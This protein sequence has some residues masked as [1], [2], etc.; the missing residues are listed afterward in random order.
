MKLNRRPVASLWIGTEIR[1]LEQ[2]CLKS[3]LR[4]GHPVTIY[5]TDDVRNLPEG[6]IA[7]PATDI[8]DISSERI[9]ETS[10]SFWSNVF[11]YKM[12]QKTG[13]IWIDCDAFCHRPFPDEWE[14]IFAG[15]GMRGALNCGVVGIPQIGELMDQLIDYYDNL[16]DYPPWWNQRQ[17]KKLDAMSPDIAQSTRIYKTERTAF[18]PQAFTHF[19]KITGHFEKA[20]RSEVLYPVPFQLNDVFYDPYGKVEGWFTENTT[21]VHL[22]TNGT[23]PWWQNNPPLPNSY[24]A[25]MCDTV[26]IDA[27]ASLKGEAFD[28]EPVKDAILY[29]AVTVK[30]AETLKPSGEAINNRIAELENTVKRKERRAKRENRVSWMD[31]F[32]NGVCGQLSKGDLAIDLGT[33]IGDISQKLLDTGADVIGFDP[34][35]L[36]ASKIKERFSS[37]PHYTF[38]QAAATVKDGHTALFRDDKFNKNSDVTPSKSSIIAGGKWMLNDASMEVTVQTVNFTQFLKTIIAERGRIAFLK[39]AIEGAEIEL[40]EEMDEEGLF[41]YIDCASIKTYER[42]FK[43]LRPRYKL[44]RDFFEEKYS[45][46]HVNFNWY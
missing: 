1:Y 29:E 17:R 3:H 15:H 41:D 39:M 12:I 18:G 13:S 23:K 8:M 25:R 34:E 33:H 43:E 24:V 35:P 37:N 42:K 27:A 16:P 10:P 30:Q 44:I 6:V 46:E 19:A 22:Y 38:Y 9:K 7:K 14:Y 5:C 11:R 4:H 32:L 21:S 40:L 31:G 45:I 2:L 20:M 26:G 36:V 28:I